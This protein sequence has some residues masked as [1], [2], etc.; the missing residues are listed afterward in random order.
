MIEA[1][2]YFCYAIT[3]KHGRIGLYDGNLN[4]LTCY[5]VLMTHEDITRNEDE[6]RRTNRW[7]TDALYCQ[8]LQMFI[9]T[10]SARTIAIYEASGLKHVP[11]WLIIGLPQIAQVRLILFK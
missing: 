10:N 6:R 9:I 11:F 3:T 4:F 2:K 5:H 7:V 8:D 1:D